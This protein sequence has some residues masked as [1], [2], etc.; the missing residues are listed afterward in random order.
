MVSAP[1]IMFGCSGH[2][3]SA[4]FRLLCVD[5][6]QLVFAQMLH[7]VSAFENCFSVTNTPFTLPYPCLIILVAAFTPG[8]PTTLCHHVAYEPLLSMGL[9]SLYPAPPAAT[10]CRD[11]ALFQGT[12]RVPA[13]SSIGCLLSR[14]LCAAWQPTE[15]HRSDRIRVLLLYMSNTSPQM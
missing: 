10:G 8:C 15:L 7:Q 13:L 11:G 1:C 5:R 12:L 14:F 4:R 3:S 6:R 9:L 2:P